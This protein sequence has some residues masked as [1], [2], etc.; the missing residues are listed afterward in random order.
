MSTLSD[1]EVAWGMMQADAKSLFIDERSTWDEQP[2][3]LQR[4]YLDMVAGM[5]HEIIGEVRRAT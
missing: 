3:W 1:E 2:A 5:R 4:K